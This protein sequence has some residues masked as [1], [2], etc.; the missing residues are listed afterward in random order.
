MIMAKS[1]CCI[2][3]ELAKIT[4][5]CV[6]KYRCRTFIVTF[7]QK[8]YNNGYD[9]LEKRIFEEKQTEDDTN[10]IETCIQ[11]YRRNVRNKKK[12]RN[13]SIELFFLDEM[14]TLEYEKL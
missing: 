3:E 1:F 8:R 5:R 12:R 7:I 11:K 4:E 9:A 6:Q 13:L 2:G 10:F 14:R